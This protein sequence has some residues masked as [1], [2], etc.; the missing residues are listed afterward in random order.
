MPIFVYEPVAPDGA[1][2]GRT[3]CSFEVLQ[4]SSE[5]PLEA[6]PNCGQPVR[7]AVTEFAAQLRSGAGTTTEQGSTADRA[8]SARDQSS[9]LIS[10]SNDSAATRAARLAYKHVCGKNCRH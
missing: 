9:A 4:W 1:T 8:R 5:A 2:E 10:G 3:C 6:C 7:R